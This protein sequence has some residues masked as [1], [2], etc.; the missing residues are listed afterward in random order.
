MS[1]ADRPVG[2]VPSEPFDDKGS[3]IAA[4]VDERLRDLMQQTSDHDKLAEVITLQFEHAR[5]LA[6]L[7]EQMNQV[8]KGVAQLSLDVGRIANG[9]TVDRLQRERVDKLLTRIHAQ[10]SNGGSHG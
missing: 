8:S 5:E 3:D 9:T 6:A 2:F 4:A 7:R 1:A 10:L